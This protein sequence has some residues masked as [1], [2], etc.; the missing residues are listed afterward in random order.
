MKTLTVPEAQK[1][2]S[3]IIAD[4]NRGEVIVLKDGDQQVTLYP[5]AV[6]DLEED[7]PELEAEL[8]KAADGPFTPYSREAL[9]ARTEELIRRHSAK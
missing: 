4:V 6:L 7:S 3:Q 1:Q 2:L 9:R 8:L 5:G